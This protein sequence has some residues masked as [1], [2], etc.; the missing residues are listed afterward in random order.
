[1]MDPLDRVRQG[2]A[3]R[4][5]YDQGRA[6]RE[7][8]RP[9]KSDDEIRA[10]LNELEEGRIITG[11]AQDACVRGYRAG[12]AAAR[13]TEGQLQRVYVVRWARDW[14]DGLPSCYATL[15][16]A[17]AAIR[18]KYPRAAGDDT[19]LA[20]G[21]ARLYWEVPY[22]RDEAHVTDAVARVTEEDRGTREVRS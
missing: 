7:H 15:E 5:G 4:E 6:D 3:H 9:R 13:E 19:D 11:W 21:G 18:A 1:M 14:L 22:H 12:W 10:H 16:S 8:A 20:Y 2:E 17:E